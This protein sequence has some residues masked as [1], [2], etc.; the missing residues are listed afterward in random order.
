MWGGWPM[1][2][3]CAD[4]VLSVFWGWEVKMRERWGKGVSEGWEWMNE[5]MEKNKKFME[6]FG[7]FEWRK[8]CVSGIARALAVV[9]GNASHPV[10]SVEEMES[11][12][13]REGEWKV[14]NHQWKQSEFSDW[15]SLW[16]FFDFLN[17]F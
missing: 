13:R 2:A 15:F 9:S 14:R 3:T 10:V 1:H 8:G 4:S 17:Y 11:E 12:V 7:L 6:S 16:I 5:C